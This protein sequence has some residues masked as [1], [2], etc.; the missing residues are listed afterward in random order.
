MN[1]QTQY[2]QVV[3][4][5]GHVGR[6]KFVSIAYPVVASSGKEAAARVRQYPRVKHHAKDAIV[7]CEEID[8]ETFRALKLKNEHDPY[9]HCK[10][11]H[12]LKKVENL[13]ERVDSREEVERDDADDYESRKQYHLKKYAQ[14]LKSLVPTERALTLI[15]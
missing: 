1:N 4:K 14:W 10:N 6:N 12:D 3:A 13:Y 9:L 8:Y 11:S 7:S 15:D 2:F 5:C